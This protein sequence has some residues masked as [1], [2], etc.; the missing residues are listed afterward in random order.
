M[1]RCENGCH[2]SLRH[3]KAERAAICMNARNLSAIK[4]QES[5][6]AASIGA[7]F[8]QRRSP[9]PISH[10]RSGTRR[11]IIRSYRKRKQA[12]QGRI[13]KRRRACFVCIFAECRFTFGANR[14]TI[15][16]FSARQMH[17]PGA[18]TKV[19]F[20]ACS[21]RT[22]PGASAF[23]VLSSKRRSRKGLPLRTSVQKT[24][25]VWKN[26][27]LPC[28]FQLADLGHQLMNLYALRTVLLT[29][30]AGNAVVRLGAFRNLRVSLL[31]GC[32]FFE[33]FRFVLRG[34]WQ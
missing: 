22:P 17:P 5:L 33:A 25:C 24:A 32:C 9:M 4:P 8:R 23:A 13:Q 12:L 21:R 30:K 26:K 34:V 7:R 3:R 29:G 16:P 18:P 2:H 20:R 27:A 6:K 14:R 11:I 1:K 28:R 31:E 10:F 15:R 19:V